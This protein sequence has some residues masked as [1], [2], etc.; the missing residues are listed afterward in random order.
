M[1][2]RPL[3]L[4][5]D[6]FRIDWENVQT[7]FS[8]TIGGFPV[9]G[10]VNGPD[11]RTQGY[12]MSSRWRLTSNVQPSY[13][14]A[15]TE[16]EWSD[17]KRVRVYAN[18]TSCRTY[19]KGGLLGDTRKWKHNGGVCFS[20]TLKDGT[21][22]WASLSARYSVKITVDRSHDPAVTVTTRP[23]YT[24]YNVSAGFCRGAVDAT[25]WVQ[26]LTN[27][28]TLISGQAGG[29]MG[30]RLILTTPRTV[31]VNVSYAFK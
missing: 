8:Q 5:A 26:N 22:L 2:N 11:A 18:D 31:A 21:C 6:Y 23:P 27:K 13:S 17:A 28:G 20:T 10:T 1:F 30:E 29:I 3:Y 25:L 12:E 24:L 7:Y 14:G 9:N 16:G 4:Q 19:L 15:Y